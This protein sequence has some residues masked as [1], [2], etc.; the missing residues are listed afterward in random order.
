M[1][2]INYDNGVLTIEGHT[3]KYAAVEALKRLEARRIKNTY[4]D[5]MLMAQRDKQFEHMIQDMT[6]HRV[7]GYSSETTKYKY[8]FSKKRMANKF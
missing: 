7:S 6:V 5:V 2:Y 3:G 1:E 8:D 4:S